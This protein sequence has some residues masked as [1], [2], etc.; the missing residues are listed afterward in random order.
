[1]ATNKYKREEAQRLL[2]EM[3]EK[4]VEPDNEYFS[5]LDE[6]TTHI[7]E[8]F[9]PP[10]GREDARY[11]RDFVLIIGKA[12][13]GHYIDDGAIGCM[14]MS[15]TMGN[16]HEMAHGLAEL[17]HDDPTIREAI[18]HAVQVYMLTKPSKP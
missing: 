15:Y 14:G 17:M 1:M 8:H 4:L 16:M 3:K 13:L 12:F 10:P 11:A 18:I 2:R 6:A 9:N 7:I 5:P